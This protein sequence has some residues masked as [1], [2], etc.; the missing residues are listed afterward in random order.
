MF[1]IDCFA[2]HLLGFEDTELQ[3]SRSY[4][5]EIHVFLVNRIAFLESGQSVFYLDFQ[6]LQVYL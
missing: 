1:R 3:D 6:L 5:V 4:I 2:F